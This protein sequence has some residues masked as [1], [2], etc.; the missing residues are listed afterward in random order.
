MTPTDQIS[1]LDVYFTLLT[2]SGAMKSGVPQIV[3]LSSLIFF[4]YF[5]NPKSAILI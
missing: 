4:N 5:E 1:A 3:L 2:N